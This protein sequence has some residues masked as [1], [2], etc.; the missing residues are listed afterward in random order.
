MKTTFS[1]FMRIIIVA[2]LISTLI[3]SCKKK[4]DSTSTT[5]PTNPTTPTTVTINSMPQFTGTIGTANVSLVTSDY[6]SSASTG[7][8]DAIGTDLNLHMK[9]IL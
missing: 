7:S 6:S 5:T 4:D 2:F 8:D 3:F 9:H 1:N